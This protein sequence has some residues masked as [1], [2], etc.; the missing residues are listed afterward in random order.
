[1]LRCIHDPD[2]LALGLFAEK[3]ADRLAGEFR[4]DVG[5]FIGLVPS[6]IARFFFKAPSRD[7]PATF[8]EGFSL[9]KEL[10]SD[11]FGAFCVVKKPPS[12]R[13]LRF[14][15]PFYANGVSE[16]ELEPSRTCSEVLAGAHLTPRT[17]V[18]CGEG[19]VDFYESGKDGFLETLDVFFGASPYID[20]LTYTARLN[21]PYG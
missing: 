6:A 17:P 20:T 3:V 19:V 8:R 18:E 15:H 4:E 7:L 16:C 21:H 1:M 10:V 12:G 9:L 2:G 14:F 11:F 13:E 5:D